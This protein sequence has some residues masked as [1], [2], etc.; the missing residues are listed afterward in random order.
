MKKELRNILIEENIK[1]IT[2]FHGTNIKHVNSIKNKGLISKNYDSPNW[3]MVSTDFESALYHSSYSNEGDDV[4]VI[5]FTL[6][7]T[8]NKWFGYPFLW[9]EYERSD[10]SKWFALKKPLDSKY[11][12]NIEYISYEE[13]IKQKHN[14]F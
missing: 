2:V 14:G 13:Y 12:T 9:P 6:P 10:N 1:N 5:S 11:I 7:I 3:Y 8:D 4:C